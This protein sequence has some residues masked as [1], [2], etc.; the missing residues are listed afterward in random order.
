MLI[1]A[2]EKLNELASQINALPNMGLSSLSSGVCS[3]WGNKKV[4]F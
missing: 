1:T 3:L 2:T 4:C